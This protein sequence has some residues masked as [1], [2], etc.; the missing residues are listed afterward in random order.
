MGNTLKIQIFRFQILWNQTLKSHR[1]CTLSLITL[2]M[3]SGIVDANCQFILDCWFDPR[4]D[5]PDHITYRYRIG[6]GIGD[7]QLNPGRPLL[8]QSD[9]WDC[10]SLSHISFGTTWGVF[11][12]TMDCADPICWHRYRM[13]TYPRPDI[14]KIVD[15]GFFHLSLSS[16]LLPFSDVISHIRPFR[17]FLKDFSSFSKDKGQLLSAITYASKVCFSP[18]K[19]Q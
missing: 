10:P 15:L 17:P 8:S 13:W 14:S 16:F 1:V 5:G 11:P 7:R 4:A 12:L 6:A 19:L 2:A 9:D 3:M 18:F